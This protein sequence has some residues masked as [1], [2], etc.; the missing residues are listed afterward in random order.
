MPHRGP[1]LPS[2]PRAPF[3]RPCTRPYPPR[4][5]AA[6]HLAPACRRLAARCR[7]CGLLLA[8]AGWRRATALYRSE[9]RAVGPMPPGMH[10]GCTCA[11]PNILIR[12]SPAPPSSV[13]ANAGDAGRAHCPILFKTVS[14]TPKNYCCSHCAPTDCIPPL[15]RA[16]PWGLRQELLP[17]FDPG[18]HRAV[19]ARRAHSGC[20]LPLSPRGPSPWT[21][22]IAGPSAGQLCTLSAW[23]RLGL[24]RPKPLRLPGGTSLPP[25]SPSLRCTRRRP[26]AACPLDPRSDL[27]LPWLAMQPPSRVRV[28]VARAHAPPGPGCP[29]LLCTFMT[30]ADA[31]AG[32]GLG[33][34]RLSLSAG[35]CSVAIQA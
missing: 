29:L 11:A 18:T 34:R 13:A 16:F 17:C 31:G 2:V 1:P 32:A 14:S 20:A 15:S 7:P 24:P 3:A 23:V 8:P 5:P 25:P 21:H 9:Q 30:G 33:C 35:P 4:P 27:A 12:I 22:P 6:R 28:H 26:A 10:P 19:W